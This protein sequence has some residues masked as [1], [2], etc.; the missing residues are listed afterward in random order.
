MFLEL[1]HTILYQP[2]LNLLVFFYNL[3]PGHDLGIAIILLT[4]IIKLVFAPL[5]VQSIKAQR[6]MQQL[7]PKLE[8]LKEKYKDSREKLSLATMEMYRQEKINPLSSCLPILIQLPFLIAV[9]QVFRT[10]LTNGNLDLLYP[11]ISN[12]GSL[13]P[14]SLGFLDLSKASI[15]MAVLAGLAQ[16]WQSKMMMDLIPKHQNSQP[17]MATQMS[18]QMTYI[19][20]VITVVIGASLPA[21]LTLYWL[22]MTVLSALQQLLIFNKMKVSQTTAS[23]SNHK[24]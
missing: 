7:Q 4:I 20:P 14:L 19:M 6:K 22:V 11:F 2:I 9:Y 5:F 15:W 16:F 24:T 23:E 12:P 8:A 13:N 17:N 10:G 21:G 1:Y 18:K 3:I